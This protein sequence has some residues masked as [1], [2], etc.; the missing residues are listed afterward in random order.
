MNKLFN[1]LSFLMAMAFLLTACATAV[2]QTVKAAPAEANYQSM[3][4]R[5]VN[6]RSVANFIAS[7][8]C[9]QSGSFQLCRNAGLALWMDQNQIVR[10]AYLYARESQNFSAYKGEL[11]FGLTPDDT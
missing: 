5:S 9:D 1:P 11:P 2:A 7:N 3:L 4:G 6:D 10:T 8:D